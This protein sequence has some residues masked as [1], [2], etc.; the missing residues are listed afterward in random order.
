MVGRLDDHEQ[1][2]NPARNYVH[3][4][5]HLFGLVLMPR[6]VVCNQKLI[7]AL[8]CVSDCNLREGPGHEV[9]FEWVYGAD[10][11]NLLHHVLSR[12]RW[13]GSPA[14]FCPKPAEN[15]PN[16]KYLVAVA[17]L[18]AISK[19]KRASSGRAS[20][21]MHLARACEVFCN[22]LSSPGYLKAVWPDFCWV[23]F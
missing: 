21:R 3:F 8:D 7:A 5:Y 18:S 1:P 17:F 14:K 19:I 13:A 2:Q 11:R 15:L 6:V 16:L 20:C 10:L 4:V 12:T 9:V 22:R 23:R